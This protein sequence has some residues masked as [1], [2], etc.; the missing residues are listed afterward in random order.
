MSDTIKQY[1]HN[2]FSISIVWDTDAECP[3]DWC[4][5][6]TKDSSVYQQWANGEVYGYEIRHGETMVDSLWGIYGFDYAMG[7]AEEETIYHKKLVPQLEEIQNKIDAL[8][9]EKTELVK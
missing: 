2:G 5:T 6:I 3:L 1:S 8:E 9:A 4:D 7:R